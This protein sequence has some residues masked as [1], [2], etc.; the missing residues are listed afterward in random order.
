MS[1]EIFLKK[2]NNCGHIFGFSKL[3]LYSIHSINLE[4]VFANFLQMYHGKQWPMQVEQRKGG[5]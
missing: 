1:E 5:G 4:N 3:Q 2:A